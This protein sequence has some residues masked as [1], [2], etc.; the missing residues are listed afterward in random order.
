MKILLVLAIVAAVFIQT[1]FAQTFAELEQK[2]KKGDAAAQVTLGEIYMTG[3]GVKRNLDEGASWF[4]KAAAQGDKQ[5]KY[6]LGL[7]FSYGW[8]V[9]ENP[10]R[11]VEL[12]VENAGED[13]PITTKAVWNAYEKLLTG[14]FLTFDGVDWKEP[15]YKQAVEWTLK[16]SE[17]GIP[18]AELTA[19]VLYYEGKGVRRDPKKAARLMRSAAQKGDKVALRYVSQFEYEAMNPIERWV[20]DRKRAKVAE[21]NKKKAEQREVADLLREIRNQNAELIQIAKDSAEE[22]ESRPNVVYVSTDNEDG[23]SRSEFRRLE[24]DINQA[25]MWDAMQSRLNQ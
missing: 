11:A 9:S 20:E 6:Y 25:A 1:G 3:K 4:L 10:E 2:A 22:A 23:I 12:L 7:C 19:A 17:Q 14:G 8:G 16:A 24:D 13:D 15:K 18:K 5:A 21:D